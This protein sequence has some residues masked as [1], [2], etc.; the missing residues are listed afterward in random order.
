MM[1]AL[2][3]LFRTDYR[4][5]YDAMPVLLLLFFFSFFFFFLVEKKV[6]T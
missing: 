2:F 6:I 5:I 1:V 3:L 4:L